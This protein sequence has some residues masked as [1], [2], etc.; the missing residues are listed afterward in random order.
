M[1]PQYRLH[2]LPDVST[3]HCAERKLTLER[4]Q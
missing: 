2:T 3:C 1:I 4:R